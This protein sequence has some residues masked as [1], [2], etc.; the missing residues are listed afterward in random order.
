[1]SDIP[2]SVRGSSVG[3]DSNLFHREFRRAGEFDI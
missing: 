2:L 3:V 1:M